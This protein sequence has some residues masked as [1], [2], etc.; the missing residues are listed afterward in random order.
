MPSSSSSSPTS[1]AS[2]STSLCP[3]GSLRNKHTAGPN[4]K[5]PGRLYWL[6]TDLE[7]KNKFEWANNNNGTPSPSRP[8]IDQNAGPLCDCKKASVERTAKKGTDAGRVFWGCASYPRGCHFFQLKKDGDGDGD[9][10][11]IGDNVGSPRPA[12]GRRNLFGVPPSPSSSCPPTPGFVNYLTDWK[13]LQYIEK[14]M[15][16]ERKDIMMKRKTY[17]KLQVVG[18]W[19]ILN[20]VRWERYQG[21]LKNEIHKTRN[22]NSSSDPYGGRCPPIVPN[23]PSYREGMDHL[24]LME[25]NKDV[26]E[27]FL[28]HSTKP[29][30][31]YDILFQGLDPARSKDGIFGRGIY[32]AEN[33]A[34]SDKHAERDLR[35]EKESTIG[36]L[37]ERIYN[38]NSHPHPKQVCY[39]LVTRVILGKYYA[40]TKDG[41]TRLNNGPTRGGEDERD[42]Q[43]LFTS[44]N[45][46]SLCPF[47]AKQDNNGAGL[48]VTPSSL[49]AEP[50]GRGN[51]FRE[52]VV[53][54][55]DR[56]FVEYLVAYKRIRSTCK[57]GLPV[58]ERTVTKSGANRGRNIV[59]CGALTEGGST[60]CDFLKMMPLC[61][62]GES[63]HVAKS[64]SE[65]NPGRDYYTCG[66]KTI[67]YRSQSSGTCDFFEWVDRTPRPNKRSRNC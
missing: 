1:P 24:G 21:A 12:V 18:A 61:D 46:D 47:K 27:M 42:G 32:F 39:C 6:C 5:F 20:K 48:S 25:L 11:Q 41:M 14:M 45:R 4:S 22:S 9:F 53:F 49:V 65:K 60:V 7:C 30:C 38:I 54:D 15:H 29:D 67:F 8:Y 52:F 44:E 62:C 55:P 64:H 28:L 31:L 35:F 63:A 23:S 58:A 33:A 2:T 40:L 26:N 57:C 50:G 17:D 43:Q 51:Q 19:K 36:K 13:K 37:H 66:R 34:N 56:I 16:V 3:C 10:S 59:L